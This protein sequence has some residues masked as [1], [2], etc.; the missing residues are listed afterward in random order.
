[1]W[2]PFL[3]VLLLITSAFAAE[4][5]SAPQLI[6]LANSSSPAL[7]AAITASFDAKELK[8]GTA[9]A[10]HGPDFFFVTQAASEP[11]LS[12]DNTA[13]PKIRQIAGSDLWYAS[14]Q[15]EVSKLPSF[16]YMVSGAK[17]GG[18][19]DGPAF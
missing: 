9:W 6:S 10:G 1:M 15:L 19:L 3:L 5:L 13:G 18:R 16:Y 14:A 2:R 17:F 12:V 8:E 4:K 11:S 7:R